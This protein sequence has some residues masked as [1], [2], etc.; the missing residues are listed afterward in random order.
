[1]IWV[2]FYQVLRFQDAGHFVHSLGSSIGKDC[3]LHII[4]HLSTLDNRF[5]TESILEKRILKVHVIVGE[6]K[7][8]KF[9]L[10]FFNVSY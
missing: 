7:G 9:V 1:M 2:T 3:S 5:L 10:H 4:E 8:I 6:A